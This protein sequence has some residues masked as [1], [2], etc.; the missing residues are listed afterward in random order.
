MICDNS[1]KNKVGIEE[2]IV[3]LPEKPAAKFYA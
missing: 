1:C 3:V 2:I